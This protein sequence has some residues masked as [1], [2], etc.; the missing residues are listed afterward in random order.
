[1]DDDQFEDMLDDSGRWRLYTTCP[2]G[3]STIQAFTPAEWQEGLRSESLRF[4]CLYCGARWAPS[5]LQ[6]GVIA[7]EIAGG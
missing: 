2:A 5:A 6:R 1:M 7:K 4:E 3:H